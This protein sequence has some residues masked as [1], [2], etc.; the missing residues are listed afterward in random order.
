MPRFEPK[1]KEL[2]IAKKVKAIMKTCDCSSSDFCPDC[3]IEVDHTLEGIRT[4]GLEEVTSLYDVKKALMQWKSEKL[5]DIRE[6]KKVL[7]KVEKMLKLLKRFKI[8]EK[9]KGRKGGFNGVVESGSGRRGYWI[10]CDKCNG[11]GILEIHKRPKI[12]HRRR[13]CHRGRAKAK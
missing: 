6:Y 8:C 10:D 4:N 2:E 11:R 1:G 13:R 7:R 5:S 9:C 3:W 12:K